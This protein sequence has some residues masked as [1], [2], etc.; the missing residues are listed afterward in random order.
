MTK[1]N[2]NGHD[3]IAMSALLIAA[4][5]CMTASTAFAQAAPAASPTS[6]PA[7]A[8]T[9]STSEA[10]EEDVVELSP[11]TVTGEE[12]QGYRARD[13]LA[14]SRIRTSLDD[15]G[16][17]TSVLTK[18][19]LQD[20]G[21]RNAE[22]AL[23]YAVNTEVA[24]QSGN[25]SGVG[26][27]N[28]VSNVFQ[29]EGNT[30]Q[31]TRVRGLA[32]ADNLRDFYR[33]SIPW[34]S[35][36]VSRVDLQRGPN[37]VL[38]GIGSPAGI[39]NSTINLA[40]YRD[41]G[42]AE[43]VVDNYGT[44]RVSADYNKTI[45]KNQLAIRVSALNDKTKY[46]QEPAYKNDK[47]LFLAGR[48]D[49]NLLRIEGAKTTIRFNFEA[50]DIERNDP[51]ALTP[52]DGL[53]PWY[54]QLNKQ[55]YTGQI[56]NRI[57]DK[58]RAEYNPWLTRSHY[59]YFGGSL[60]QDFVNGSQAPFRTQRSSSGITWP[61]VSYLDPNVGFDL[62]GVATQEVY[63][64]NV[65]LKG[66]SAGA[67]KAK[68][69]TDPGIFDFYN[70]MLIGRNKGFAHKFD[71]R[72]ITI[73]QTFFNN[74][75]GIEVAYNMEQ[76]HMKYWNTAWGDAQ[77]ITVDL[78]ETLADGSPNPYLG[79][80]VA[81]GNG[82]A[83]NWE[84]HGSSEDL[85]ATA[86]GEL[87]ARTFLGKDSMIARLLGRHVFT[88]LLTSN[89]GDWNGR[90]WQ[91]AWINSPL[92]QAKAGTDG[93]TV[94]YRTYL[95]D[96]DMR[97]LSS[98][99]QAH[100]PSMQ[101]VQKPVGGSFQYFDTNSLSYA[102]MPFT[103]TNANEG[104]DYH[105][106]PYTGGG[107]NEIVT[108]SKALVWQGYLLD[109]NLIPMFGW[110]E[111]RQIK[112]DSGPAPVSGTTGLA[113]FNP[114]AY[115]LPIDETDANNGTGR[116]WG[117]STTRNKTYSLVAKVPRQLMDKLPGG[118]GLSFHYTKSSNVQPAA[119]RK[120]LM[121][122]TI[123][124]PS[125]ETKEIGVTI[126][127]L[128]D[129]VSLKINRYTTKILN[130]NAA[131]GGW[132]LTYFS[133]YNAAAHSF[134][135][136]TG[137]WG[138]QN[139]GTTS[140]SSPYGAG[141]RVAYQPE[142]I[143]ANLLDP[144]LP[145]VAGNYTQSSLD[146]AYTEQRQAAEAWLSYDFGGI[147]AAINSV[148]WNDSSF[149]NY[150]KVNWGVNTVSFAADSESKGWEFELTARPVKGLDV[151]LNASK[152]TAARNSFDPAAV[153]AMRKLM[154]H[155]TNSPAKNLRAWSGDWWNRTTGYDTPPQSFG[156][157]GMNWID[158]Q[159]ALLGAEVPELRPWRF[160]VTANYQFQGDTL[161]GFNVGGSF[162]WQDGIVRGF[163]VNAAGD[164][165]DVSTKYFGPSDDAL[166]LWIGYERNLT[167]KIK[168]RAQLNVRNALAS[169]KLI[170]IDAQ[171]DG[172]SA[173]WSI[174]EPRVISLTNTF[175][176]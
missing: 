36:N 13:T 172:S 71:A 50:G 16:S 151:S 123:P 35:Y 53:T 146:A 149:N 89:T 55:T 94:V 72:N 113:D 23:V 84:G 148:G 101:G 45:L 122:E 95:R 76:N 150:G 70:N 4:S 136:G 124:S 78:I 86:F 173:Q 62:I 61:N 141:N 19:F 162:R 118:M 73:A 8:N 170:A 93:S 161:K 32:A 100:L 17:A 54:T 131:S 99:G 20:T 27:T 158:T 30:V 47:R 138:T 135:T 166:D 81:V 97:T 22:Q 117:S 110:R 38:F 142:P 60:V 145:A 82:R 14:G 66:A 154:D 83:G 137:D 153:T 98:P 167:T 79:R 147:P 7:A 90:S 49:S 68:G 155:V 102:Q 125:G 63:A 46:R 2:P 174:P 134:A 96:I 26:T 10:S 85:R 12:D 6:T 175:S 80:P 56:A 44:A 28:S 34:D 111:D 92:N 169:K 164:K 105:N 112:K 107:M 29:N 9:P 18:K 109:G 114:Q 116:L 103:L 106:R 77:I 140:A 108:K 39:I 128:D 143:A 91:S 121:N 59:Q 21:S 42:Q 3:G 115:R 144:N 33:T 156:I 165:Y 64:N 132:F 126:S 48:W 176:F 104:Y 152:T 129:K 25:F 69:I 58:T 57:V 52:L 65:G 11:F 41:G 40:S 88:G 120:N 31:A 127:A 157:F 139:W 87:N 37:S 74:K 163:G 5:I 171:P 24:G 43:F 1:A 130:D 67:W 75:A 15:V 160:N 168:W 133:L 159:L 51:T 119:G